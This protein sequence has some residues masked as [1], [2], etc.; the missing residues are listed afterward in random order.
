[1]QG[2]ETLDSM[3]GP[4]LTECAQLPAD[5]GGQYTH[6]DGLADKTADLTSAMQRLLMQVQAVVEEMKSATTESCAGC[7][8]RSTVTG[9]GGTL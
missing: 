6:G 8:G 5:V 1:M 4:T 2:T 9:L 3:H 7:A